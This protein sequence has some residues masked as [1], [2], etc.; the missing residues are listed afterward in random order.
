MKPKKNNSK[1]TDEDFFSKYYTNF[2]N[3]GSFAGISSL[4]RSLKENK[5]NINKNKLV[6]WLNSYDTYTL[7]KPRHKKFIRNKIIVSGIDDTW[8][9][10]LV[11]M[12]SISKENDNFSFIL[13]VIDVF[14]KFAWGIPL[15]NKSAQTIIDSFKKI[16]ED[17]R[18]P[19]KI[20]TDQGSEFIN[21]YASEFFEKLGIKIYFINSETKAAVVERFNRTIKERM[22]RFFTYSNSRR[23][24]DILDDLIQSYNNS[25]HR[26]IKTKPCLVNKDNENKIFSNLYGHDKNADI[27]LNNVRIKYK[28]GDKVRIAKFKKTFEKGYTQNWTKEIFIVHEVILTKEIPCYIIKDYDGEIIEGIFYEKELQKVFKED[29]YYKYDKILKTR[30]KNGKK[31]YFVSWE[32]YPSKFNSWVTDLVK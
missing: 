29:E 22:W 30:I 5:K 12:R 17:G 8:Q 6:N 9:A 16:F 14:S 21:K 25:Y 24:I 31:Q 13:M 26:S 23:Y 15:K 4:Y 20:H 2:K 32:G 7:H 28:I 10:D 27:D 19:K 1:R 11:D 18:I 3:P